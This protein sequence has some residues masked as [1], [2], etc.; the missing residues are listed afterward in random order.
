MV[1]LAS[2]LPVLALTVV[3]DG[4]S[5]TG[6]A[7]LFGLQR[8]RWVCLLAVLFHIAKTLMVGWLWWTRQGLPA[9]AVGLTVLTVLQGLATTA[10]PLWLLRGAT[11]APGSPPAPSR[12]TLMES[13]VRY[14]APLLGARIT[15]LSG[16][17]LGKIVLGKLFDAATLGFFSFA[18]QTMERFVEL[19][20]TLPASLLPSLTH[21]VAREERERLRD[22][23]DQAFRLIQVTA[24]AL[25]FGVFVFARELTLLVGSPLFEPA[26]P[27]LRIMALVPI[28]RTAQ[29]PLTM[30]F[31]ALRRPGTVLGLALLKFAGEFG[32][33]LLLV[34]AFGMMGAGAANLI[35]AVLAYAV[36]LVMLAR[37]L[38]E[39]AGERA[40]VVALSVALTVPLLGAGLLLDRGTPMGWSLLARLALVPVAI[41][42]LFALGR[43]VGPAPD[44]GFRG[45]LGRSPGTRGRAAEGDVT[46]SRV[47]VIVPAH[48]EEAS[49]PGT[50]AELR[51][52][53]PG[54]DVLVVDDGSRD[55]TSRA[56]REAGVLVVR[57]AVNLGVGG[58]VQ[59]GF[60]YA[61]DRGYD[62]GVQL[63]A[64]G[65][66]DPADLVALTGPV[67]AGTCDV[68]IGS[69][70]LSHTAY[71]A[72]FVR[73]AGMRLFSTVV[74]LALGSPIADT[75]SGV[76]AYARPVMQVCQ[77]EFPQ[78]FPDAPLLIALARRGFR[79]REFSVQ[80]RER[81]A[82]RSFYTLGKSLYYPYKNLLA[83]I[84]ALLQRPIGS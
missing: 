14:C 80:M 61:V 26:V 66:H 37:A 81:H 77:H 48:D 78:D 84:M 20:H 54:V 58:A 44:A 71:H 30:L 41:L 50:L 32:G 40:R 70:Y 59:T 72:P 64:D 83:S 29:Q 31:Q 49:L 82:G 63:D 11:D 55:Q 27:L 23:F 65:Q 16:Q 2:L 17:N 6:R 67:K 56:A 45:G 42:A 35:G 1:E 76:R 33:Y 52:H 69:R 47:L 28:A 15:F 68:A 21:L 75:T 38:P 4:F 24:C 73:R 53:A 10:V 36:A 46:G 51:A 13:I 79:L 60:R 39:G 43:V 8:F 74:G 25:S 57:H 3:F 9:L 22:V 18:F 12:R 34:R 5:T 7:T 19:V 62:I